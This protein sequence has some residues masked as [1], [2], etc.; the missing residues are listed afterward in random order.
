[1]HVHA[2]LKARNIFDTGVKELQFTESKKPKLQDPKTLVQIVSWG[3]VAVVPP[4]ELWYTIVIKGCT[5]KN[6]GTPFISRVENL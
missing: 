4:R 2:Q 6:A 1:M 3:D 5:R